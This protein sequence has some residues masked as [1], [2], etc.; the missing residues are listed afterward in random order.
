MICRKIF[1]VIFFL[2]FLKI[3]SQEIS[4]IV[5][6]SLNQ[7]PISF[8]TITSNFNKNTITNEEGSFRLF[9]DVSFI[10][11]D[12]IYISSIGYNSLSVSV[13]KIDKLK[14][15]LSPK[16]IALETVIVTNREKLSAIEIINKVNQNVKDV[17]DFDYKNKKIFRR[18][19]IMAEVE[20]AEISIK[21]LAG[22]IASIIN[23]NKKILFKKDNHNSPKRRCPSMKE[24]YKIT[25][26]IKCTTIEEGVLQ[27]FN[28]FKNHR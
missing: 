28:Y 27:T 5:I 23:N 16:I 6:D 12:S 9:K 20:R 18:K 1:I 17:F 15:P 25:G 4:G 11:E 10:D 22:I 13:N 14:I 26:K 21:K 19:T 7:E 2:V 24:T 3:N 8:A